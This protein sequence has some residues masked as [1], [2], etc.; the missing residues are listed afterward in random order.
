MIQEFQPHN[1]LFRAKLLKHVC[2]ISHNHHA[3]E[4]TFA[5]EAASHSILEANYF[6]MKAVH[7]HHHL[8]SPNIHAGG[9]KET[10]SR[11]WG[12]TLEHLLEAAMEEA[13]GNNEWWEEK[14][15]KMQ[16]RLAIWFLNWNSQDISGFILT[17]VSEYSNIPS[18]PLEAFRLGIYEHSKG[19][20]M[21]LG[22]SKY[23]L[24]K[25]QRSQSS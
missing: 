11:E 8:I 21:L 2:P 14:R 3:Y 25:M 6:H 16:L 15:L 17:S 20:S 12:C 9:Q 24:M 22:L 18:A 5:K 1:F 13:E 4:T 19:T 23:R 10:M 7:R